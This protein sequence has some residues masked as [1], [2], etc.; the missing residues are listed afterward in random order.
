[1]V[2]NRGFPDKTYPFVLSIVKA[3]QE[4]VEARENTNRINNRS[5]GVQCSHTNTICR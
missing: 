3:K 4:K 1:M 2:E 5:N